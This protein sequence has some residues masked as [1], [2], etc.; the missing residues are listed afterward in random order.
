MFR[1]RKRPSDRRMFSRPF[2][3]LWEGTFRRESTA[4]PWFEASG[5]KADEV[6]RIFDKNIGAE[7][8]YFPPRAKSISGGAG[9]YAGVVS[10]FQIDT[11]VADDDGTARVC[12]KFFQKMMNDLRIGLFRKLRIASENSV[13]MMIDPQP[14]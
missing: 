10:R 5:K 2:F 14:S 11:T 12:L 1:C 9:E 13:E 7:F 6:P 8:F 3:A 4:F